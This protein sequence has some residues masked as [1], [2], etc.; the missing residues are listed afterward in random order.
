MARS[1]KSR[2][3]ELKFMASFLVSPLNLFDEFEHN[4]LSGQVNLEGIDFEWGNIANIAKELKTQYFESNSGKLQRLNPTY[5]C[6]LDNL[7]K[8]QE[9]YIVNRFKISTDSLSFSK[10]KADLLIV[11]KEDKV[12]YVSVKDEVGD[13]KLGQV[14]NKEYGKARLVGGFEGVDLSVFGIPKEISR[15]DTFLEESQW[16]KL[17]GKKK[18]KECAYVK[19]RHPE[20]WID[21][22]DNRIEAAYQCLEKF[23][24]DI[25]NDRESL[26]E[27]LLKTFVGVAADLDNYFL[28]L[29]ENLIDIHKMLTNLKN[30]DFKVE[31]EWYQSNT[32]R[33]KR[34]LI[35]WIVFP[36]R[37]YGLTKIEPAFDGG[38]DLHASQTKGIIYYF[39]Q[40]PISKKNA[41][42]SNVDLNY[43]NLL[44]DISK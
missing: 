21:L 40:W 1:N 20:A 5:I 28:S 8:K 32:K 37:R 17:Y 16:L 33:Q 15:Q 10:N 9:E 36:D 39:Q 11:N 24:A 22:V 23:S 19:K 26:A 29:G 31:T 13:S 3:E 25:G 7:S 2:A 18:H 44:L 4:P 35:I 30:L 38:Y 27:F 34:S 6:H 43:K 41:T 12:I 14:C 42:R